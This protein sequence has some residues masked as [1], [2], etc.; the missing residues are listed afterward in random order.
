MTPET[1]HSQLAGAAGRATRRASVGLGLALTA[2]ITFAATRR[3]SLAGLSAALAA[4]Q[5]VVTL[6]DGTRAT[7]AVR[8]TRILPASTGLL[9]WLAPLVAPER[10]VAIPNLTEEYA[11]IARRP[12]AEA[13][14]ARP[15]FFEFV[16][17]QLL[18]HAPDLVLVQAWNDRATRARLQAAGV[19][20]IE[21]PLVSEWKDLLASTRLLGV[22]VDEVAA[23][24]ALVLD[25]EARRAALTERRAGRSPRLVVYSNYN[26]G[27][28]GT[29]CG[30]HSTMDLCVRL[31]GARNVATE[32]GL[33]EFADADLELLFTLDPDV[34]V[35]GRNDD[36][37]S[38]T[39]NYIAATPA[40][41]ELRAVREGQVILL[42]SRLLQAASHHVVDGAEALAE[43]L[44]DLGR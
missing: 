35:I 5:H 29:V 34:L 26:T 32:R 15:R 24:E 44:A 37:A 21:L 3:D 38:T 1:N 43:A 16:S 8:P 27:A 14:L 11:L 10:L 42:D 18:P 7:V 6:L 31:A 41:A 22:L 2:V 30:R 28:I 4:P 17:E 9:D 33:P 13:L 12:G 19:A 40:F 23:A 25:L 39:Q 20:V 36:G